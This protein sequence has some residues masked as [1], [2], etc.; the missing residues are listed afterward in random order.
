M[1]MPDLSSPSTST[2]K[3]RG[4]FLTI[5]G[6][7]NQ[8]KCSEA[9]SLLLNTMFLRGGLCSSNGGVWSG[10][11]Y[12]R[13]SFSQEAKDLL[14]TNRELTT[15]IISNGCISGGHHYLQLLDTERNGTLTH[16]VLEDIGRAAVKDQKCDVFLIS[17]KI[18]CSSVYDN[19]HWLP[20]GSTLGMV[21]PPASEHISDFMEHLAKGSK[22][23]DWSASG[24]HKVFL[25]LQDYPDNQP[26]LFISNGSL[27]NSGVLLQ[28]D[29]PDLPH[30]DAPSAESNSR[31]HGNQGLP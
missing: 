24:I 5:G 6:M 30:G 11:S 12:A 7:P 27:L 25:G 22:E 4:I 18:D 14:E 28:M 31:T 29:Q 17:P 21:A 2:N 1:Q 13:R 8:S 10:Y 16:H 3:P 20:K 19:V 26:Q 15:I 23:S 9:N